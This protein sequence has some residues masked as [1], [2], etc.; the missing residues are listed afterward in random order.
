MCLYY[1]SHIIKKALTV[2]R[3]QESSELGG[4]WLAYKG[5][6]FNNLEMLGKIFY[7]PNKLMVT[8]S[9]ESKQTIENN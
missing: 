5:K 7:L 2:K 8:R 3:Y 1:A 9:D 6:S 4:S